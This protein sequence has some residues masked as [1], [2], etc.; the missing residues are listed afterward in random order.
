MKIKLSTSSENRMHCGAASQKLPRGRF[1]VAKSTMIQ[2]HPD[3]IRRRQEAE[4]RAMLRQKELQSLNSGGK[5]WKDEGSVK[6]VSS[7]QQLDNLIKASARLVVINFF[8]ED[9]YSCK[10]L[11][12]KLKKI[13]ESNL[14]VVFVKANGSNPEFASYFHEAGITAVP[15]FHMYRGGQLVASL[16]A[17]LSPEKLA[18]FRAHISK[19]KDPRMLV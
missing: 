3:A 8:A 1:H 14:D 13:A 18:T 2:V 16:S 4:E 5:W 15:W 19:H 6:L 12:P 7:P 17:S 9:C 11:H 10:S